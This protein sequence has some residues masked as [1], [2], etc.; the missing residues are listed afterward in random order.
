MIR[1]FCFFNLELLK[2]HQQTQMDIKTG[3]QIFFL[4]KF[5]CTSKCNLHPSV[6]QDSL[7]TLTHVLLSIQI[8]LS[9][10]HTKEALRQKHIT[11]KSLSFD[12]T[13]VCQ[14]PTYPSLSPA[15]HCSSIKLL[16]RLWSPHCHCSPLIRM[17]DLIYF[18]R[19]KQF[20]REGSTIWVSRI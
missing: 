13:C 11:Y 12:Q 5:K 1:L 15:P 6:F 19:K 16:E 7:C 10:A 2:L 9:S 18:L 3:S 20:M 14:V 8:V 4:V 17:I